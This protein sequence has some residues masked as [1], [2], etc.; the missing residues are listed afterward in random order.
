MSEQSHPQDRLADAAAA[1]GRYTE[2]VK[3]LE[4]MTRGGS[5]RFETWAKLSAMRR[6]TGDLAG[7]LDAIDRALELAPLDFS[8]L[9]ARA[10]LL[11]RLE[12]ARAG[13]A[14]CDACEQQPAI[15]KLPPAVAQALA[16]GRNRAAAYRAEMEQRLAASIPR[17][18]D[19]SEQVRVERFVSNTVRRTRAWHQEPSHFTF[20][21]LP[22]IEFYDPVMFAG[23]RELAE[24]TSV[25]HGEFAALLAAESAQVV[26]YVQYPERVPLRQWEKLNRNPDWSALH[27]VQNG[28]RI[29][30]N[31]R[32]CPRTLAAIAS[33]DQPVVP[34]ASP[35]VMFSLLAPHTRIPPH[36]GIANTRLVAHLPLIVPPSCSFRCG[37]QTRTW[38]VGEPLVFDDTIEHEAWNDS[39]ELRVVLILDLWPPALSSAERTAVA[40]LIA[41]SGISATDGA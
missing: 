34:G 4:Q 24:Q 38:Q 23:L 7:A 28:Q 27:L 10:F 3:H 22:E 13:E 19:A 18:L 14:F 8:S 37:A 2:A 6:A 36:S 9:L 41:N 5:C 15:D 1:D 29:E 21:G 32:H 25:I 12:P 35:N 31:A 26:P 16:H 33:L 11:E 17:G 20:P 30:R 39:D 40:L